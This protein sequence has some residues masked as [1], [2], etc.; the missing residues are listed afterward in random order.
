MIE[1][2]LTPLQDGL[3]VLSTIIPYEEQGSNQNVNEAAVPVVNV[4]FPY[5]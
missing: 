5:T 4:P 2:S 1:P 3:D